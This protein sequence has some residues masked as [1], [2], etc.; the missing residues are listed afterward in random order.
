MGEKN[1][2]K[3]AEDLLNKIAKENGFTDY[4]IK[5]D[6]SSKPGEGVAGVLYRIKISDNKSD[7]KLELLCKVA[8]DNAIYRKEF[9]IDMAFH[10][11]AAFYTK[12]MPAF[13]KFQ[14]EKLLSKDDQFRCYPRCYGTF[15]NSAKEEY[16]IVLEDLT[17][18]GY[19]K[20][21]KSKLTPIEHVRMSMR[22]LGKF[23]GLSLAM[24]HQKPNEFQEFKKLRDIF[25][26]LCQSENMQAMFGNSFERTIDALKSEEHKNIV[27]H[28]KDNFLRYVDD[29]FTSNTAD[30]FHVINH[31]NYIFSH[32]FKSQL[33]FNCLPFIHNLF[34]KFVFF[35]RF[36]A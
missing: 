11:E 17:V 9:C 12:L 21:P 22:E 20:W 27:R 28:V 1:L 4:T 16:A 24:K 3:F 23:H 8:P 36:L 31:G 25:W 35:R 19:E 18:L 2:P 34:L 7:K 10:G 14:K 32:S 26:T 33:N 5:N 29:C 15:I 13:V 6:H 30:R